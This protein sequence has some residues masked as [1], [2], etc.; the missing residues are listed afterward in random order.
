MT[1]C[2]IRSAPL[3][4]ELLAVD[5]TQTGLLLRNCETPSGRHGSLLLR[6]V[7]AVQLAAI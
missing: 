1:S 7:V 5:G 2:C 6:C 4:G 3:R